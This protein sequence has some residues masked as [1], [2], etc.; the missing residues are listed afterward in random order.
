MGEIFRLELPT[1]F[2]VGP[3]NAWWL[4]GPEPVLIDTGVHTPSSLAAL[5]A[6]LAARG[7]RL[8]E[9]RRILLTHDHYDHAGA[10]AELHRRSGAEI[11]LHARGRLGARL[12]PEELTELARFL[13]RCG[14]PADVVERTRAAFRRAARVVGPSPPAAALRRLEGGERLAS[15][16]GPLEVLPTP[17]HSPDHVCYLAREAGLLFCGDTLLQ[18]ITPNPILWLDPEDGYRRRPSLLEYLDSLETLA[19]CPVRLAHPGHGADL[20]DV[21][22]LVRA[23]QGFVR[24]RRVDFLA[25]LERGATT[26]GELALEVF[27]ERPTLARFLALSETVAYLDLLERDAGVEVD[28]WRSTIRVRPGRA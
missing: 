20:E 10:A 1:P 9:L 21:P 5:E 19:G 16:L 12:R 4:D 25:G 26:P 14:L 8:G 28:W 15:P 23:N 3:A 7:R 2:P 11:C 27:G 24:A 13:G 17:G 18:D 22:A 6:Q